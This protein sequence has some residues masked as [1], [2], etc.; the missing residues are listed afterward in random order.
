MEEQG[1]D[2]HRGDEE[3]TLTGDGIEGGRES[4]ARGLLHHGAHD[5]PALDPESQTLEPQGGGAKGDDLRVITEEGDELGR[6]NDT[7]SAGH[8]QEDGGIFDAEPEALF[9]AVK[10]PGAVIDAADR[11]EALAEAQHGGG[12]KHHDP[13]D[14][15][16][17]G[18][19]GVAVDTGGVVQADGGEGS[20]DLA[21]QGG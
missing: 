11:L 21:G 15:A 8:R 2:Q 13:L 10:E 17:G 16:H 4:L 12:A 1:Q 9:D 7:Q 3:H 20:Q 19:G 14:N 6:K 18:D 5:D